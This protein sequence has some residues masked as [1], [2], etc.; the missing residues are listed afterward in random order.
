[1]RLFGAHVSA[2]GGL[3]KAVGRA[4]EVSCDCLQVF[5]TNPPRQWPVKP[6]PPAQPDASGGGPAAKA[7]AGRKASKAA[8]TTGLQPVPQLSGQAARWAAKPLDGE[9]VAAWRSAHDASGLRA[10]IAHGSY[11]IN[12]GSPQDEL[13]RKS[14]DALVVELGRGET[15][16]L[17]GLV[18]HPGAFIEGDEG[19]GV[20]RVIDGIAEALRRTP[21]GKCRLLLENTAGQGTCLGYS[22]SQLGEI[23]DGV[24]MPDRLGICLD[25]CHAFAA[26]YAIHTADGLEDFVREIRDR[27]P[28]G[29][30][31]A[32]HLNDSKKPLGSRVDRHEHIGR[33][34]IGR[35]GFR[36]FLADP[37]FHDVPGYLE[38]EKGTDE[39]SGLAWDRVNLE[40]LRR[41]AREIDGEPPPV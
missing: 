5:V 6:W 23:W 38:T 35:D 18:L 19:D 8:T 27:L 24:S 14:V 33:G 39:A 3:A 13:F 16:G 32:L 10:P 40:T 30:V 41:L 12:L 9:A 36:T 21:P 34:E 7:S 25:T 22:I 26:G 29:A 31:R 1:M 11:L 15:L 4:V 2:Q 20:R 17:E 28:N 37:L